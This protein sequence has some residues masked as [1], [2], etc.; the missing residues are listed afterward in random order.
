MEQEISESKEALAPPPVELPQYEVPGTT[1]A[2][3][4]IDSLPGPRIK[5]PF[6]EVLTSIIG[7][8]L[9]R[10][11]FNLSVRRQVNALAP[12]ISERLGQGRT[13]YLLRVNA[14]A[15]EYGNLYF[16]GGEVVSA[17]GVGIEPLDAIAETFRRGVIRNP[18][19]SG[20]RDE[21][22]YC[23]MVRVGPRLTCTH[24]PSSLS[25]QLE[26]QGAIEAERRDVLGGFL[27]TSAEAIQQTRVAEHWSEVVDARLLELEK[28]GAL[29]KIK[30]LQARMQFAQDSFN[31]AYA[32]Y[33][34]MTKELA[35]AA[36]EEQFL[37][38][39]GNVVNLL[40]AG[41][42]AYESRRASNPSSDAAPPVTQ[43][44]M[45]T[46]RATRTRVLADRIETLS[47]E[48][49]T[50]AGALDQIQATIQAEFESR[51]I[52]FPRNPTIPR[53][54]HE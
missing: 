2:F 29:E 40:A 4:L 19:P 18:I 32:G 45:S 49:N 13:G 52:P 1:E 36:K 9:R 27:R 25:R 39:V 53:I 22:R 23:W 51:K 30:G 46:I 12:M 50:S 6:W 5:T 44:Q 41:V 48:V 35:E 7:P 38:A 47:V 37:G 16:P 11:G 21:S 33:Q 10:Y 34:R 24:I 20:L 17:Y 28:L 42:Q 31:Q 8:A 14:Y 26:A 43:Q 3:D 54:I 15:D